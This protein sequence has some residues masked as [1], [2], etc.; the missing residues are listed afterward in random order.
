M[1]AVL[2]LASCQAVRPAAIACCACFEG[3]SAG[4]ALEQKSNVPKIMQKNP[5]QKF[6][7]NT[8]SSLGF[9]G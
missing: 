2:L 8:N 4:Q 5:C 7:Q 1:F 9:R 3:A 6:V